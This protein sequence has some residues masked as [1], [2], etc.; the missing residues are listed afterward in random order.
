[1]SRQGDTDVDSVLLFKNPPFVPL[2]GTSPCRLPLDSP[3]VS[4]E[5]FSV[6]LFLRYFSLFSFLLTLLRAV[7]RSVASVSA[8]ETSAFLHQFCSFVEHQSVDV[9]R[10]WVSFLSGEVKFLLGFSL[11]EIP[12][13]SLYGTF[14]FVPLMVVLHRPVKPI[15]NVV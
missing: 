9:H 13:S 2:P 15:I 3:D 4:V 5:L 6:H 10:I 11:L 7:V 12:L 1:M 14:R 8:L